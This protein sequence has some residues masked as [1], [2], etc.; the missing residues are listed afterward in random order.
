MRL[1]AT[2]SMPSRGNRNIFRMSLITDERY[3]ERTRGKF[4]RKIKEVPG[5]L[6]RKVPS[7]HR[8]HKKAPKRWPQRWL[9]RMRDVVL[10]VERKIRSCRVG[11]ARPKK[12]GGNYRYAPEISPRSFLSFLQYAICRDKKVRPPGAYHTERPEISSLCQRPTSARTRCNGKC[13][14]ESGSGQYQP[15]GIYPPGYYIP[16]PPRPRLLMR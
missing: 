16:F 1:T 11:C 4:H 8:F 9:P 15:D 6:P 3:S 13:S 5:S 12:T 10:P 14:T 7:F 2:C